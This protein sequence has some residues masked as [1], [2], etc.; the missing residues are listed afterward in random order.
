VQTVSNDL[1]N[2]SRDQKNETAKLL[3]ELKR[4]LSAASHRYEV[5]ITEQEWTDFL[6]KNNLRE[7]TDLRPKVGR[8]EKPGWRKLAIIIIGAYLTKHK[9]MT[10]EEIKIEE[11]A[12]KI[13]EI[14]KDE[15]TPGLPAWS[16][17]KDVLTEIRKV[18]ATLSI[19]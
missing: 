17:I 15:G 16:T 12:K 5:V 7:P 4:A 18:A 13:H 14:A 6:Q 1:E 8:H 19:N 3:D 10:E 2:G 11:A 9:E